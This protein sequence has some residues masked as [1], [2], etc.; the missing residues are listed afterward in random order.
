MTFSEN[1]KRPLACLDEEALKDIT[2]PANLNSGELQDVYRLQTDD[3]D[4]PET[5]E[6]YYNDGKGGTLREI[7]FVDPIY[8]DRRPRICVSIDG[9]QAMHKTISTLTRK[10]DNLVDTLQKCRGAYYKELSMLREQIYQQNLAL[11]HG[12]FPQQMS[13]TLYDPSAYISQTESEVDM[14]VKKK[15]DQ[16]S[17]RV[18]GLEVENLR[19]KKR[20]AILSIEVT[21]LENQLATR[22][23][24]MDIRD[25]CYEILDRVKIDTLIRTLRGLMEEQQQDLFYNTLEEVLSDFRGLKIS[26]LL[27]QNQEDAEKISKLG[28]E[29]LKAKQDLATAI[30]EEKQASEAL[31]QTTK[32]WQTADA[33]CKEVE[34]SLEDAQN[35]LAD[36]REQVDDLKKEPASLREKMALLKEEHKQEIENLQKSLETAKKELAD[37]KAKEPP[38][39]LG[40]STAGKGSQVFE[41]MADAIA[42]TQSN[43]GTQEQFAIALNILKGTP[44]SQITKTSEML[45]AIVEEARPQLLKDLLTVDH[46]TLGT[47]KQR[48]AMA[49][50]I[51]NNIPEEDSAL[52]ADIIPVSIGREMAV[53]VLEASASAEATGEVHAQGG[54][55]PNIDISKKCKWSLMRR[56]MKKLNSTEV[57][58][59]FDELGQRAR[60]AILTDLFDLAD[61]SDL[62]ACAEMI[63]VEQSIKAFVKGL[64][65]E[66]CVLFVQH[67]SLRIGE[68]KAV[69]IVAPQLQKIKESRQ[70]IVRHHETVQ[71]EFSCV[72]DELVLSKK[73]KEEFFSDFLLTELHDHS[74]PHSTLSDHRSHQDGV[75]MP[76]VHSE[77]AGTFTR[78]KSQ[79]FGYRGARTEEDLSVVVDVAHQQAREEAEAEAVEADKERNLAEAAKEAAETK[80]KEL[81]AE[82]EA[83]KANIEK[84]IQE[85]TS[86]IQMVRD[87]GD[88]GEDSTAMAALLAHAKEEAQRAADEKIKDKERALRAAQEAAE[89]Q[90][91]AFLERQE[92]AQKAAELLAQREE[93]ARQ[94]KK[95]AEEEAA[96]ARAHR[97]ASEVRE[98][99]AAKSMAA[100]EAAKMAAMREREEALE[101]KALFERRTAEEEEAKAA[102]VQREQEAAEAA[103][104]AAEAAQAAV[105]ELEKNEELSSEEREALQA[106]AAEEQAAKEAAETAAAEAKALAAFAEQRAIEA[107]KQMNEATVTAHFQVL[108]KLSRVQAAYS[109][110]EER[111]RLQEEVTKSA[112]KRAKEAE[113]REQ[114][115]CLLVSA[116]AL[117]RQVRQRDHMAQTLLACEQ[118]DEEHWRL[119]VDGHPPE[120]QSSVRGDTVKLAAQYLADSR[121]DED[122]VALKLQTLAGLQE[123]VNTTAQAQGQTLKPPTPRLNE[124]VA[125]A[126]SREARPVQDAQTSPIPVSP[127]PA[128]GER[129]A[130]TETVSIATQTEGTLPP[131]R[132]SSGLAIFQQVP[133]SDVPGLA[134]RPPS[135]DAQ[136][137]RDS[138]QDLL[139]DRPPSGQQRS[140]GKEGAQQSSLVTPP[141]LTQQSQDAPEVPHAASIHPHIG[142]QWQAPPELGPR[143]SQELRLP[144]GAVVSR[145]GPSAKP[146]GPGMTPSTSSASL[147]HTALPSQQLQESASSSSV[148]ASQ[149]LSTEL[150]EVMTARQSGSREGKGGGHRSHSHQKAEQRIKTD[151]LKDISRHRMSMEDLGLA[152]NENRLGVRPP[153]KTPKDDP[154]SRGAAGTQAANSKGSSSRPSGSKSPTSKRLLHLGGF[155]DIETSMEA[156]QVELQEATADPELEVKM[157]GKQLA[158]S[159]GRKVGSGSPKQVA[160]DAVTAVQS[161][162]KDKGLEDQESLE[163][164]ALCAGLAA[165]E[166]AAQQGSSSITATNTATNAAWAAALGLGFPS[167]L[168]LQSASQALGA[169]IGHA[170]ATNKW[171]PSQ[172]ASCAAQVL[173]KFVDANNISYDNLISMTAMAAHEAAES[174]ALAQDLR[175]EEAAIVGA[176]E[177]SRITTELVTQ[178]LRAAADSAVR[179]VAGLSEPQHTPLSPSPSTPSPTRGR[180]DAPVSHSSSRHSSRGPLEERLPLPRIP[181]KNLAPDDGKP[182][183]VGPGTLSSRT[184]RPN[185]TR[186][187]SISELTLPAMGPSTS[188]RP[189]QMP[190]V[191]PGGSPT[192]VANEQY[193]DASRIMKYGSGR[194]TEVDRRASTY[195]QQM[196]ERRASVSIRKM[197][198]PGPAAP[199]GPNNEERRPAANAKPKLQGWNRLREVKDRGREKRAR[200]PPRQTPRAAQSEEG[201]SSPEA[202]TARRPLGAFVEHLQA[203]KVQRPAPVAPSAPPQAPSL[204]QAAGRV[205]RL[206]LAANAKVQRG[207]EEAPLGPPGLD[208]AF[209]LQEAVGRARQIGK[210]RKPERARP[211]IRVDALRPPEESFASQRRSSQRYQLEARQAMEPFAPDVDSLFVAAGDPQATPV[212]ARSEANRSLQPSKSSL[213][214]RPSP[215]ASGFEGKTF[216]GLVSPGSTAR[217]IEPDPGTLAQALSVSQLSSESFYKPKE[218]RPSD[219][220]G[221]SRELEPEDASKAGE[222]DTDALDDLEMVRAMSSRQKPQNAVLAPSVVPVGPRKPQENEAELLVKRVCESL[223]GKFGSVDAAF[224]SMSAKWK[225]SKGAEGAEGPESPEDQEDRNLVELRSCLV[226]S[227]VGY[228]DATLLLQAMRPALGGALPTLQHVANSLRPGQLLQ[229]AVEMAK[230]KGAFSFSGSDDP[231]INLES[232]RGFSNLDARSILERPGLAVGPVGHGPPSRGAPPSAS[233]T[234]SGSNSPARARSKSKGPSGRE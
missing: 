41:G 95:K 70:S 205:M 92:A 140:G 129:R 66:A 110:L 133:Q 65:D 79:A 189:S 42:S 124:R 195:L 88:T 160:Q 230:K 184:P 46:A 229:E 152:G 6:V 154:N 191:E 138:M 20:V 47:S 93:D 51:I 71:T 157:L 185:V 142:G 127:S 67:T 122:Q 199:N 130:A 151:P 125:V 24:K 215:Q 31:S 174:V 60:K 119:A 194:T 177:A 43:F 54:F 182:P 206:G 29:L 169:V 61:P 120:L 203:Q 32:M 135:H 49:Q 91:N 156:V 223:D 74:R 10:V 97:R 7:V 75:H 168:A 13:A 115:L 105:E 89:S 111:L 217:S 68:D 103:Q 104:R 180:Q 221:L 84:E 150:P 219:E 175:P 57:K 163:L 207:K 23:Q 25:M 190:L 183:A 131:D 37:E 213:S 222:P 116:K 4:E 30:R 225:R 87:E 117:A 165:A 2:A 33:F 63:F 83:L 143:S 14:E 16:L 162:M 72:S 147:A 164:A 59:L 141:P 55:D 167:D 187:L 112:E 18:S 62:E 9:I 77:A 21:H 118:D 208:A 214:P 209:V 50:R 123:F 139:E 40:I 224:L 58:N 202:P 113:D 56:F 73:P 231:N 34:Q 28:L 193:P 15:T 3:F 171:T 186:R 128:T 52:V 107:E 134:A 5:L 178:Q 179:Q 76:G 109:M 69:S 188:R 211:D 53:K 172:T 166:A 212:S 227:G 144:L 98:E 19:L 145:D 136:I 181:G 173:R 80:E 137:I 82:L 159:L 108:A 114:K 101:M 161:A 35:E 197:E 146:E 196:Q 210:L 81:A 176:E 192:P 234:P 45:K 204:A 155:G 64:S 198:A 126:A 200:T 27:K 158:T 216:N 86:K 149:Q 12:G 78:R 201:E 99:E 233:G 8:A 106:K 22:G 85:R 90:A 102:A 48:L 170:A 226:D 218:G 11:R 121:E 153:D 17:T 220:E 26:D 148:Q 228:K 232:I 38:S 1:E 36:V 94:A 132:P 39:T 44:N 100:A 96:A